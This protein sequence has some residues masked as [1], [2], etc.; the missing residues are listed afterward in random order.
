MIECIC[1]ASHSHL[2]YL[3]WL[4]AYLILHIW[5]F[6]WYQFS[7]GFWLNKM[8]CWNQSAHLNALRI[9]KHLLANQ[10]WL[11]EMETNEC[12]FLFCGILILIPYQTERCENV[13][14]FSDFQFKL[15]N[16]INKTSINQHVGVPKKK[17]REMFN[18]L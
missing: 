6:F 9:N 18:Y 4:V 3:Q 11:H 14:I 17:K 15:D 16:W 2:A 1:G 5:W 8:G 12:F 13:C 10:S 7:D